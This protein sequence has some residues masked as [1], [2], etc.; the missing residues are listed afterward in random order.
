ML[1]VKKKKYNDLKSTNDRL[2]PQQFLGKNCTVHATFHAFPTFVQSGPRESPPL[3]PAGKEAMDGPALE[4]WSRDD[5]RFA[6]YQYA[7]D[8][9]VQNIQTKQ[10]QPPTTRTQETLMEFTAGHIEAAAISRKWK[11]EDKQ[12]VHLRLSLPSIYLELLPSSST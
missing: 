5:H 2:G 4:R 11:P 9:L 1:V 3:L 6:P 12:S 8:K 10:W 7:E